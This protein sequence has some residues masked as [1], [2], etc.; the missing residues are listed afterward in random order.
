MLFQ[1]QEFREWGS[2]SDNPRENPNAMLDWSK[3]DRFRGIFELYRDLCRLRRN[4]FNNTRGL[5][6][7]NLNV[8]HIN[9]GAKVI[10]FHRWAD[11]GPGDGADH[12]E[13]RPPIVLVFSHAGD[14]GSGGTVWGNRGE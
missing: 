6:G 12:A 2:W 7:Q 10:A 1:G 9:D 3:K 8:F 11:G 14:L 13:L 5:R 4:W